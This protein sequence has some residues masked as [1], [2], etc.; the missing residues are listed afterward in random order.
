MADAVAAVL[1]LFI[2]VG[3]EVNVMNN[4]N[5]R[6]RQVYAQTASLRR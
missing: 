3:V 1:G 5:I 2:V 4:D 6:R